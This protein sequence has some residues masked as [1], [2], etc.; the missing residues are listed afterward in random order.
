VGLEQSVK[1]LGNRRDEAE[2]VR[3]ESE[4]AAR[5]FHELVGRSQVQRSMVE[6]VDLDAPHDL[7]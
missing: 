6:G 4:E 3:H 2:K 1:D 5:F 7:H